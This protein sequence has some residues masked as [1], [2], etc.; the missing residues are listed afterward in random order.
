MVRDWSKGTMLRPSREK[1]FLE[2]PALT[3]SLDIFLT[4]LTKFIKKYLSA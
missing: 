2:L 4:V 3:K 1:G